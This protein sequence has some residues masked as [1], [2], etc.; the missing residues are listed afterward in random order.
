MCRKARVVGVGAVAREQLVPDDGRVGEE[1]TVDAVGTLPR[2]HHRRQHVQRLVRP[3]ANLS[4]PV[5][6]MRKAVAESQWP[7]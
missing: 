2:L 3:R 1:V 4:L 6:L 7:W 5:A